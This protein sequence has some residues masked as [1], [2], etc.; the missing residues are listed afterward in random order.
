MEGK[1]CFPRW[2]SLCL[3]TLLVICANAFAQEVVSAK[4]GVQVISGEQAR[5]A[6]SKDRLKTGDRLR[7]FV[8]P[9]FEAYIY[10]V[11]TDAEKA[12]LLSALPAKVAEPETHFVLP[13]LSDFYEIDGK[14][15][16]EKISV[17][18]ST[19]PVKEIEVF[20]ESEKSTT[21]AWLALETRLFA[22]HKTDLNE[23]IEKP[24]A[25]AGNVRDIDQK[26]TEFV[27]SLTAYSGKSIVLKRYDFRVKK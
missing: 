21:K 13:S 25:I 6:K 11:H 17:F 7:V 26:A 14:S 16:V 23:K 1:V 27:Q 10:V 12:G 18:C 22:Q 20:F 9:D 8:Q 19:R 4:V 24:F 5:R 3:T 2:A 15:S